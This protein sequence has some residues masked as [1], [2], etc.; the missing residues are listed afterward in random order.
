MKKVKIKFC[1]M[2]TKDS[3]IYAI[4]LGVAYL[5]FVID[6]P[7]SPRSISLKQFLKTAEWLKKNKKG[8]YKIVAVS[9]DMSITSIREIINSGFADVI[10]LHGN[11]KID[12]IKKMKGIEIW[13]AWSN[14]SKGDVFEMSK[15]VDRILLDSGNALEKAT[16]KSGEFDGFT[17]YGKLVAKKVSLVLSGGIDSKNVKDY[18]GKLKPEIIDTSRGIET[19]PGKKSKKKMKEL[20]ETVND[21]YTS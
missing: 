5:G 8:K 3:L 9:V 12:V 14:R 10:Q 21:Y 16:N 18:L 7:K 13:K 20:I 6:Y 17:L 1:G 11:E 15:Q 4:D 2:M 19:L